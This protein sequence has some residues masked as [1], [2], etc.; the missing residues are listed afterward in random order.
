MST[1]P[2]GAFMELGQNQAW[3][4]IKSVAMESL[5][6]DP[7]AERNHGGMY[8]IDDNT[9]LAAQVQ[10]LSKKFDTIDALSKKFDTVLNQVI[11]PHPINAHNPEQL[12]TLILQGSQCTMSQLLLRLTL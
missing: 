1:T 10:A 11:A 9:A 3:D 12:P 4:V 6:W 5:S 8:K 2:S 7:P